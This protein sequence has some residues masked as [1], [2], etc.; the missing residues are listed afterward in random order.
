VESH[1]E[2]KTLNTTNKGANMTR[3]GIAPKNT[4]V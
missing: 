3:V 4:T 1:E 2:V